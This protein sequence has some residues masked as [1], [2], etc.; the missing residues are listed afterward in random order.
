MALTVTEVSTN[1]Q[2][3][4]LVKTFDIT[5]DSSYPTNGEDLTRAQLGFVVIESAD[6]SPAGG[7]TFDYDRTNQKVKAYWVDTTTDG[8]P[9]AEVANATNLSAVTT[10]AVFTG[11]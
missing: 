2:G 1:Y 3:A 4:R 10:R 9:Q 6:F 8:A 5:G 11:T 7:Y